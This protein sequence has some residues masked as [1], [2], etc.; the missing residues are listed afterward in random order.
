MFVQATAQLDQTDIV[1]RSQQHIPGHR[2]GTHEGPA[3]ARRPRRELGMASVMMTSAKW[4]MSDEGLSPGPSKLTQRL[5]SV[6]PAN[7]AGFRLA[8]RSTSTRC[9]LPTMD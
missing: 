1:R 3:E 2:R 6:R 4:F 7:C 5:L 9:L 8:W